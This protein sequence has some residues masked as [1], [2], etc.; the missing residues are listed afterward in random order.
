[1]TKIVDCHAH[2]FPSLWQACGFESP[3]Q[4][5]MYMQRAMHLH[6]NQPVRSARDHRVV[7]E[8]HLW[9]ADDPSE[10]GRAT[11]V[12]FRAG[13]YGRMEWE[14][15][16][17]GFYIQFLPPG[18][19]DTASPAE[20]MI[21]QMDYVGIETAV[22]QNDHI[23]GNLAEYFAEAAERYP[24][25][26]IGLAQVDEAFAYRDDQLR[27]LDDQLGRLKM[28]GLYFT[29]AGFFRN[30]YKI[31]YDDP[32][33]DPLWRRV[34]QAGIPVFWVF[35]GNSPIGTFADEMRRFLAFQERQGGIPSVMVHGWPTAGMADAGDR[36]AFPD[37]LTALMEQ[38]PV[39]S[40][41]LYPIS[42]GRRTDYPYVQ[43]R[44]HI[45]QIYD[46]FGADRLMWGSD[47]PNVERYCTYRQSLT[48]VSDYCD[49]ISGEDREKIFRRNTLSLLGV[50][51]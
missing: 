14:K 17:E 3:E 49:F 33:F 6:G 31:Y 4:H 1:M 2:I 40:E 42:W 12:R 47:M 46:R 30:A 11:D 39:Y 26:F 32:A 16:G 45:R 21:T 27:L 51:R 13:R 36:I 22:L 5:A 23:Y 43:A 28:K 35:F 34:K 24:G 19:Q 20:F 7:A 50:A 41:I 44:N 25:R 18:M 48:Y 38:Y 8:K 10:T 37:W 15:D 9:S 29:V